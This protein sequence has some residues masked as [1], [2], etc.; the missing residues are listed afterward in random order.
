MKRT[1]LLLTSLVLLSLLTYSQKKEISIKEYFTDAEFFFAAE[2]Y[3]DALQ[4]YM[5]VYNRGYQQNPNI[6]YHIGLCYLNIPE[7]HA[8]SIDYLKIAAQTTSIRY[9]GST[10]NESHAPI[11]AFLY[12]GNAYRV[13]YQLD[14][15]ITAYNEY[16][17]ILPDAAKEERKFALKQIEACNIAKEYINDPVSVKFTNLG[18]LINTNNINRNCVI[19]GD[20]STM[21]FMTKLPFYEGIFMSKR[22]GNNWSRPENITPQL[23]SDGDQMVTGISY[24][25][26]T[27]LLV[28][29]DEFDSDVYLSTYEDGKW[30]KS[31]DI[32]K[33][34]NSR[35]W[36]SHASLSKDGKTLY[37]TSNRPG[38]IG[39][40]D[41]YVSKLSAVGTWSDPENIGGQINTIYN[42]D[43]PFITEDDTKLYF[44][45]QG[46]SNMGGYDFFVSGK[47][48]S[49]WTGAENLRYPLSTTD[50]DL[51]FYPL[52]NGEIGYVSKILDDS[53]GSFDIYAIEYVDE[54]VTE[55]AIT[56]EVEDEVDEESILQE[57]ESV[58]ETEFIAD[59]EKPGQLTDEPQSVQVEV[60]AV[61]FGFDRYS[62]NDEAKVEVDKLIELLKKEGKITIQ[63]LAYTDALGPA[64]YNLALS[65]RRAKAIA[66]YIISKGIDRARV[67]AVGK[68]EV[69][70]IA[71]NTNPDGSDNP[72]GRKYNRRAEFKLAGF[73]KN[74]IEIREK[75][76][77][78]EAFRVFEK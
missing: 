19:S 77:V 21:V 28:K 22:R 25:G 32:G 75:L 49:G 18:N 46:N 3:V 39:G 33:V 61:L 43:T 34:I 14:N 8:K 73:D 47:S 66:E 26:S 12:L 36:E 27:L 37:F 51:F 38:G 41:I 55:E 52:Q 35:Y 9:V 5:E 72:E 44:S 69:D 30:K 42:E 10:L 31:K 16:L 7:Q 24:D 13:L 54:T 23:Q 74:R 67:K 63:I 70:F 57:D 17:G 29:Q 20:G 78:P 76:I 15:A 68:G 4:D 1:I 60:K 71:L 59:E 53:Y 62:L 64:E 40:M 50:N 45:S 48:D 2:A 65:E 56:A 6:N 58:E 11:D